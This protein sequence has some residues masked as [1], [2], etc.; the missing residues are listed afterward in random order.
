MFFD[1]H[2]HPRKFYREIDVHNWQFPRDQH[3]FKLKMALTK[4]DI[5]KNEKNKNVQANLT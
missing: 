5:P 1:P 3:L 4:K 2:T